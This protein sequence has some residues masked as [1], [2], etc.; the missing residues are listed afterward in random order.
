MWSQAVQALS[1]SAHLTRRRR[2]ISAVISLSW[3]SQVLLLH[4]QL[5]VCLVRSHGIPTICT[6]ALQ[7]TCGSVLR[8][9]LSNRLSRADGARAF[10][11][12]DHDQGF[13]YSHWPSD[14]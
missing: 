3:K 8:G 5:R 2:S 9:V 4:L 14:A 13:E 12:S 10:E 1:A 7:L 11:F 6:Y